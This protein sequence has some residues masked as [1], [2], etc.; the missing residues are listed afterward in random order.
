M[1]VRGGERLK[2]T[3]LAKVPNAVVWQNVGNI[4]KGIW[5]T[6]AAAVTAMVPLLCF[7]FFSQQRRLRAVTERKDAEQELARSREQLNA[8]L[9]GSLDGVIVFESVR[10][11]AGV[12]RDLRFTMANP[13]TEKLMREDGS[14]LLGRTLLEKFPN[15]VADGL[16]EKYARI[17]EENVTLDF[18][19][20]SLHSDP[21]RWYR[22]AGV[23]LGDGVVVS[24]N[25]ITL[26]KQYEQQLQE[27]KQRAESADSAK[28]DFLANMSHE[29][30]TPMNGVI[31]MIGLLL[32][33]NLDIEQ[34]HLAQTVRNSAESLLSLINDIL[35]FSKIES[36]Q[37]LFEELDFDLRKMVED[38]LEMMASQA[39]AKGIEL[40]SGVGPEV[41]TKLRGDPG[42][43]R[44]VL[45]NLISNA[46]KFTPSGEVAVC[47]TT[48]METEED[49]F[50]RIE[51]KDTGIGITPETQAHLFQ[52]FVQAD[53]STSRKFGGTGLGL[54][55]C[56]RLA[57]AMN[58]AIG[59]ESAPGQGSTFW[60]T[61]RLVRQP[62]LQTQSENMP[63]FDD[64]RVLVVDDNET[65][66]QFLHEQIIAWRLS[67][68][69]AGTGEEAL[70]LLRQAAIEKAP[71]SVA[72]IDM[73][74][75][76]LD[77]VALVQKIN[78]DPQ[79]CATRLILL[80]P[81][82]KPIQAAE[83]KAMNIAAC[84]VKP[85]RQS[86]LFD[87][88]VQVLTRPSED[89]QTHQSEPF[90]R[91]NDS[92]SPRGERVLLAEDNVVNQQVALGNLR[93]L[94]YTAD[95]ANNGLQVLDALKAQKYDIILM[96]CQMP[97]LDGYKTTQEIRKRENGDQRAWIIAM[98]ANV[99]VGDREKCLAAGMDDYVSKP[100]HRV[101]LRAA[102]ER[103]SAANVSLVD[104]D[105]LR[106][107][108]EGFEQEFLELVNLFITS[109]PTALR[110]IK[111]AAEKPNAADLAM[112]AHTLKGSSSNF[113]ASAL[114]KICENLE[115]AALK[116][117]MQ[118][119]PHLV[120]LADK[121]L[122]K[123]VEKL[124]SYCKAE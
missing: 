52:S 64:S 51:V 76:V 124:K 84:C 102:L 54:A 96:D 35:D 63:G 21:P 20:L 34:R 92:P 65:S 74:M 67:S 71:Y 119:I 81:F 49:V 24:Y 30:R 89:G 14:N 22:I 44:Q 23:K 111:L 31:G 17:I 118:C 123:L 45:T 57:K 106:S 94:G 33:T 19:H 100:L 109:A 43:V 103:V 8:I 9:N 88:L 66:R 61:L 75:P 110:D 15:A 91:S 37:L 97:G 90:I 46:I 117:D 42:R 69:C 32:D 60:V 79:L 12:L 26:R 83:L 77:G 1:P 99:M 78:A 53:S 48:K 105:I 122:S 27:A 39:E 4:R 116:G 5:G 2:W 56:K 82:G 68:G 50:V 112:A 80:I 25:E 85:V 10:D 29:I 114:R 16:F 18:E 28:S 40:V 3:L 93:K 87:C 38:T 59:V 101:E 11:K 41:A 47:V 120:E 55:I 6:G 70:A 73:Q 107:L 13:A 72:I 104:D 58:G 115:Q 108:K 86:A 98:T 113:G 7:G 95:V 62:A 36:G 121:E